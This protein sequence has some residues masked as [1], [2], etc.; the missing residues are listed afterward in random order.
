MN[1][2]YRKGNTRC[3]RKISFSLN[4][5]TRWMQSK[6]SE[7]NIDHLEEMGTLS[8]SK[9]FTAANYCQKLPKY[10]TSVLSTKFSGSRRKSQ[11]LESSFDQKLENTDTRKNYGFY[12]ILLEFS[13]HNFLPVKTFRPKNSSLRLVLNTRLLMQN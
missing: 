11:T 7:P 3:R 1:M 4:L 5:G 13:S 6:T 10:S 12:L 2:L 9:S 8:I